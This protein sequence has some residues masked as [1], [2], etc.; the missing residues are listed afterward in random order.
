MI[1]TVVVEVAN[2]GHPFGVRGVGEVPLVLPMAAV[3][4]AISH[5]IGIRANNLPMTPATILEKFW[6]GPNDISQQ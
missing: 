2:G 5:A 1:D 6:E 3:A 4:N